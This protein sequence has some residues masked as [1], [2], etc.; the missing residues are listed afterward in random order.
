MFRPLMLAIFILYMILWSSY[1]GCGGIFGVGV[2]G[3]GLFFMGPNSHL[4]QC[5]VHGLEENH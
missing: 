1:T 4:C 3:K 5:W 2:V